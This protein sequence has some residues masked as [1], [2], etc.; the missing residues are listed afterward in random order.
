MQ[1]RLSSKLTARS[2]SI[3]EDS[4][5]DHDIPIHNEKG[6]DLKVQVVELSV[7]VFLFLPSVVLS[8]FE[9][10]ADYQNFIFSSTAIIFQNLALVGLILFFLW[11]NGESYRLIGWNRIGWGKEFGLGLLLFP[12]FAL[13]TGLFEELFLALGLSSPE[14]ALP[15]FLAAQGPWEMLL[16]LILITV[17][18][19]GEETIYRGYLILR[20]KTLLGSGWAAAL[21][22]SGIFSLGHAYEGSAG[23]ATVAVMGLA[24]AGIYIWRGS[25]IAPV[26]MHF[27]QNFIGIILLPMLD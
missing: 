13:V 3:S 8:F 10:G 24:F 19:L 7:F 5:M 11:R 2:P 26:V 9:T 18:A 6:P 4:L 17:V 16:A 22:S 23:I 1:P 21:I 14:E 15:S 20:L 25:I 27:I 12:P